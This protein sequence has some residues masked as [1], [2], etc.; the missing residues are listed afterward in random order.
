MCSERSSGATHNNSY[1]N[2]V[3]SLINYTVK[4]LI[5]ICFKFLKITMCFYK[6]RFI[7]YTI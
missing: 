5:L 7:Y 6:H 2:K 4:Y 1:K 3:M